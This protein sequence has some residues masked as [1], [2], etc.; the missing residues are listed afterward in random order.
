MIKTAGEIEALLTLLDDTDLSVSVPVAE[1]L[2][3]M[4]EPAIRILEERWEHAD[5]HLLQ[6]RIENI[7]L[8]IQQNSIKKDLKDWTDC[9][10]EQLIYGAYLIARSQYPDLRF[11]DIDS[12][13]EKLRS[14]IWLEM[15]NR[16]TAMEKVGVINHFLF[17]VH[18][19]NRSVRGVQSPQLY[20]VNHVIDTRKGLPV[21]LSIIYA[22]LAERLNLP[23]YCV[24]LPHNFLL[25]YKDPS[26]LDDPDGIMFYINPY[27][28]GSILGRAEVEQFLKTQKLEVKPEYMRPVHNNETVIRLTEGLRFAYAASMMEEKVSF[29]EELIELLKKREP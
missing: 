22:E 10:S 2:T 16:L 14:E 27:T 25:C 17:N 4:G 1:R 15:N 23:I 18:G 6:A 11:T 3:E 24:D 12:K 20:L 26:Y 29:L 7:I 21:T 9:R 19:Y 5:N 13:I 28:R 8:R